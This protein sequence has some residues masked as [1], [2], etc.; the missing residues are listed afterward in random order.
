M[1]AMSTLQSVAFVL[2]GYDRGMDLGTRRRRR[3]RGTAGVRRGGRGRYCA[4]TAGENAADT[5]TTAGTRGGGRGD[6]GGSTD[7]LDSGG[8]T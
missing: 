1:C 8:F 3:A 7:G 5:T 4:R 2:C 6:G